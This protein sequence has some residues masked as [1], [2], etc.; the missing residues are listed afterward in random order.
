MVGTQTHLHMKRTS[1]L[2]IG[3]LL[4]A[5]LFAAQGGPDA[6]GYIWKDTAEPDGPV[7]NWIDISTT[8]TLVQGLGDDNVAGPFVMLTNFEYYWYNRKFVWIGSNGYV[9]FMNGNIASPFP[10]I[11]LA[12]GTNDYIA[13]LMSD[14]NFGGAG[15]P[16]QCRF[17]DDL[18]MTVI[19]YL[20]VPFWT[21]AAP[22]WTGSNTFQII[23]SKVDST[24]TIQ[25]LSQS[26]VTQNNDTKVGIESVAG[27]IG[28]QHSSNLYPQAGYAVRFYRP[29]STSLAV[30][31]ASVL[32]T[33]QDGTGGIFRS[34]N[35]APYPLK[36]KT[37]NI[38]NQT[39]SG[40]TVTGTVLN[41][42]SQTQVTASQ[43]VG[44][45]LAGVDTLITFGPAFNPTA[46]GTYRFNCAISG[47]ANELVTA[48]NLRTQEIVV[49]DTTAA[50]QALNYHGTVDNGV[51]ISWN[52]G[53]GGVGVYIKPPYYPAYATAY[54]I[55]IV[56]NTGA[57][58]YALKI[59]DD[60]GPNGG[61]G[62]RLDSVYVGAAQ[63]TAGDQVINLSSPLTITSGGVYVQWY[64]L[65]ANVV[66]AVDAN[67]PFSLQTYEVIDG[68]WAEYR[69]RE[70]Q[71]FFLGLRLAQIPVTDIGCT[72]FFGLTAG[73]DIT[74]PT[75]IRTWVTNF[76][77]QPVSAFNVHYRFGTG[78]VV[79]QAYSG[80]ALNPGQQTLIT[81]NSYFTP[82]A[83]AT[84]DLCA[85]TSLAGDA[86]AVNDTACLS[87]DTFV[88][89]DE[90]VAV[91]ARLAPVPAH[92]ELRIL[93]LPQG[94]WRCIITD[95][96]G[97]AVLEAARNGAGD[98]PL[99]VA[100]LPPGAYQVLLQQEGRALRS[101][102][103][104]SR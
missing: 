77:N 80:T 7:F 63:A 6:Y 51:G 70:A 83:D 50:T 4:F 40:Y 57:S 32:W 56:S 39:L 18:D 15:N 87:I 64:M 42:A 52:G 47:V 12:G 68:V 104:V 17:Y 25:Y 61:P 85:W 76:G 10:A 5:P 48:N 3:A 74:G 13:G 92:D 72:G 22:G 35:G 41:A 11:P 69:D 73:Q 44:S 37:G 21:P 54:T 103:V 9:A 101:R 49:V 62:T 45:Q 1:T 14:L 55:R 90:L 31:D 100:Q 98:W 88:G 93:G 53:N 29:A 36:V 60:N 65:G 26:G 58:A 28:L 20:N 2:L 86:L 19:S 97:R 23:L 43:P 78:P 34:R 8:G 82:T 71:D 67:P 79:S 33:G 91:G 46:A 66:I 27:T 102:F 84:A 89:I 94:A 95:A 59:Y 75:A 16:G 38:G 30:I 24:I 96:A 81:F 99:H